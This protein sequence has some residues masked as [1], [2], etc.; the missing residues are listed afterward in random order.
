[1]VAV[2]TLADPCGVLDNSQGWE[3]GTS[4]CVCTVCGQLTVLHL[5]HGNVKD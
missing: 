3:T 4:A 5:K 1:M 2:E